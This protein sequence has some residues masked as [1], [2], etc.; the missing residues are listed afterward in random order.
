MKRNDLTGQ[1]FGSWTVVIRADNSERGATRWAC[2]CAC[3]GAGIIRADAL[4]SG[5]SQCCG[6]CDH[7]HREDLPRG[8]GLA[9]DLA[10]IE[11]KHAL[12]AAI[13]KRLQGFSKDERIAELK[14]IA[15]QVD[16]ARR[17]AR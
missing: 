13:A 10:H 4:K 11:R 5:S 6:A 14:R 3:G 15:A 9:K 12:R 7:R 1:R 17:A 8:D 16:Q 2:R